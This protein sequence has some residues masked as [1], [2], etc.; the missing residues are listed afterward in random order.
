MESRNRYTK[1]ENLIILSKVSA[2]PSN[3]S[4]AFRECAQELNRSA[5]SVSTHYYQVLAKANCN[6]KDKALFSLSGSKNQNTTRKVTR[7]GSR[8][9]KQSPIEIRQSKWRR[10]LNIIFE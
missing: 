10:I 9:T 3:L 2:N 7:L 4:Q 5:G 8:A 1:E 6:T